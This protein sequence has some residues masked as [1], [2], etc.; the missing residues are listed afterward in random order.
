MA[1]VAGRYYALDDRCSHRGGPLS[2]GTLEGGVVTC[3]WHFGK[4]DLETGEVKGPPPIEPLRTY[5]V[6]VESG[7]VLISIV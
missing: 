1:K 7:N 4:F 5:E 6:R 3:P 2:E